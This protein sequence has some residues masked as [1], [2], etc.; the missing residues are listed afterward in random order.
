MLTKTDKRMILIITHKTDFTAD[1]VINKLNQKGISYKRFNCEDLF[2]SSFTVKLNG[3]FQYS[4]LGETKYKSVWFRRTKLPEIKN[5]S[6]EER[7]YILNETDNFFKNL[8]SS[9][10]AKWLSQPNA[11]YCAENKFLQLKLAKQIGFVIPKTIITNSKTQLKVFYE[12][13]N[14]N[15][16]IKPISQ[17]RV[18]YKENSEFIFTSSVSQ[19]LIQEIEMYDLT[20]CIFQENIP[21]EYEI[22]VT[23]VGEEIFAAAVY[24]QKD[25]ET[26][27]DWRK[28]KLKFVE[29]KLPIEIEQ[30]C[31]L[32]VKKLNLEFGAIDLIKTPDGTYVFLEINPNGQWVWIESQT[33]Q[34]ISEA[35][36]N[37][38]SN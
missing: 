20:P 14:K 35:I 34:K 31:L 32:L 30:L 18:Q 15:I 28:K 24:S 8:F 1:F 25:I 3:S 29:M 22:R 10:P 36:I 23:I 26:K 13:N 12:E 37:F 33:G 27:T 7:L 5:L 9:L 6:N 38:L 11:V 21:K 17:T 4:I 19:I 16:I 2:L